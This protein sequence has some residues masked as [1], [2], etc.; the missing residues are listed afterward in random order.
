MPRI[1]YQVAMSL[2]GYIAG[3]NGEA[4]WLVMDPEIDFE[5][6]FGQFDTFLMGRRT[7]EVRGPGGLT[8]G[9]GAKTVVFSRTLRPRAHPGVTV[10]AE[11]TAG[12]GAAMR[13]QAGRELGVDPEADRTRTRTGTGT[14]VPEGERRRRSG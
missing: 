10:V 7:F 4:D 3:P 2:D 12:R 6:L 13:A 11:G 5:A 8:A 9:A 1:R 14:R